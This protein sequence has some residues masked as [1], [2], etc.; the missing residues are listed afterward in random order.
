MRRTWMP[1]TGALPKDLDA[2]EI[3]ARLGAPWIAP[4]YIDQFMQEVFKIPS[5]FFDDRHG[6]KTVYTGATGE[7]T[8][9]G[10]RAPAG[11]VLVYNTYGTKERSAV[12]LLEGLPEP[13][14]GDNLYHHCDRWERETGPDTAATTVVQQK[15]EAIR[16]AFKEWVFQDLDS[17]KPCAGNTMTGTTP[18][19]RGKF[20]GSFLRISGMNPEIRLK[21]HQLDAIARILYGGNTLLAHVVGAGKTFEMVRRQWK[22]NVWDCARNP[23]LSSP[24]I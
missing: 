5:Y 14:V 8:I 11:N 16:D 3:D 9:A 22:A 24:T 7:W 10:A 13:A 18:F 6:M 19:P 20:D 12:T 23:C 4:E 15:Q 2:T 21:K 17:G 1:L